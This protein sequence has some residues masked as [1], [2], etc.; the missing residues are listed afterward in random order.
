[1]VAALVT[2]GGIVAVLLL[3]VFVGVYFRRHPEK[4]GSGG[5]GSGVLGG[6][7]DAFNPSAAGA[8]ATLD[9]QQ[10]LIV[11][12]PNPDGDLGISDGQIRIQ[13]PCDPE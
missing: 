5:V 7:F 10:R 4:Q 2:V 11:P 6:A 9:E 3:L 12:A 13:L 8:R 1:M